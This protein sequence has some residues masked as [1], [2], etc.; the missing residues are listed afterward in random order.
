M[1]YVGVCG[2]WGEGK[3]EGGEWGQ[4][5]HKMVKVTAPHCLLNIFLSESL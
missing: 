2:N 5:L 3:G 4:W 1:R